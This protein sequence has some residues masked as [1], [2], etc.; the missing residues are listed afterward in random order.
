MG[1]TKR[2]IA[3]VLATLAL[4]TSLLII[5]GGPAN[6][7][8]WQNPERC[9]NWAKKYDTNGW[10]FFAGHKIDIDLGQCTNGTH[11]LWA[12]NPSITF[13]GRFPGSLTES[14]STTSG[15][16]IIN[17]EGCN[18]TGNRCQIITWKFGV[19]QCIQGLPVCQNWYFT[20]QVYPVGNQMCSVGGSCDNRELW[21]HAVKV[22]VAKA[23]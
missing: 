3:T 10:N 12:M 21:R 6:A 2:L 13:P 9:G 11:I 16:T 5:T 20:I 4:V 22:H 18:A 7:Q 19:K 1:I 8:A 14:V 23:A 17:T 15:P